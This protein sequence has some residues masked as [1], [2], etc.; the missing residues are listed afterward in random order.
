MLRTKN[1][2]IFQFLIICE[3][4]TLNNTTLTR[5]TLTSLSSF[6]SRFFKSKEIPYSGKRWYSFATSDSAFLV[7]PES[8]AIHVPLAFV[9]HL[10][11][12]AKREAEKTFPI[13]EARNRA[14]ARF[15]CR[16]VAR[17]RPQVH[18]KLISA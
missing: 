6:V 1:R 15:P 9:E 5:S 17:R 8:P 7:S 14:I 16:H 13:M 18:W 11:I 3:L 4:K 10:E 12:T 2:F